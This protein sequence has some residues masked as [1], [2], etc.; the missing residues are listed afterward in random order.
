MKADEINTI[1]QPEAD[2]GSD[3]N[4]ANRQQQRIKD[5][6]RWWLL[7][8]FN[9]SNDEWQQ[10]YIPISEYAVGKL[11]DIRFVDKAL[12]SLESRLLDC[13]A[14]T[15]MQ[16]RQWCYRDI[17]K[18]AAKLVSKKASEK[19]RRKSTKPFQYR[20]NGD[21]CFVPLRDAEGTE[22]VWKIPSDWLK[23]AELLWPLHIKKLPNGKPYL[24]RK[25]PVTQPDGKRIQT[26]CAAHR[27]YL[28]FKY[29]TL[30]PDDIASTRASARTGDFLDWTNDNIYLQVA[31]PK[32]KLISEN[33]REFEIKRILYESRRKV[34]YGVS[35]Y[36]YVPVDIDPRE[37]EKWVRLSVGT[38]MTRHDIIERD[39]NKPK[40]FR[41]RSY[42][43]EDW[44]CD[45]GTEDVPGLGAIPRFGGSPPA[46]PVRPEGSGPDEDDAEELVQSR[47]DNGFNCDLSDES[48][49]EEQ[50]SDDD[51]EYWDDIA[52][53]EREYFD[54]LDDLAEDEYVCSADGR[55]ADCL[56]ETEWQDRP[57]RHNQAA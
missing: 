7:S 17:D 27:Y 44:L 21:T 10:P 38:M 19:R 55:D 49:S 35:G 3:A 39:E 5:L 11:P 53:T 14:K 20:R 15:P 9:T 56:R 23:W 29:P 48:G 33:Q 16:F 25:V 1:S 43:P 57:A 47:F 2:A 37:L 40:R 30:T 42:V 45:D 12:H 28:A 34:R 46:K 36:E 52:G 26:A 18:L 51:S 41:K 32:R 24:A 31:D 4:I 54:L 6:E 22:H 13:P 50:D 8:L